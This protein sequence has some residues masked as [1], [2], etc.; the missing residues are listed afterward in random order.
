MHE[1][2]RAVGQTRGS[3][4]PFVLSALPSIC[5]D[6]LRQAVAVL[7]EQGGTA[8]EC[9]FLEAYANFLNRAVFLA[10]DLLNRSLLTEDHE[11]E[12]DRA[13][14]DLIGLK[15]PP[16]DAASWDRWLQEMV[17]ENASRGGG[18]SAALLTLLASDI[19]ATTCKHALALTNLPK[20]Y[21]SQRNLI[22]AHRKTMADALNSAENVADALRYVVEQ[23]FHRSGRVPKLIVFNDFDNNLSV[24]DHYLSLRPFQRT[25]QILRSTFD[26]L[27]PG[28]GRLRMTLVHAIQ[29]IPGFESV[30]ARY[31]AMGQASVILD[32]VLP[33][34]DTVRAVGGEFYILT[35]NFHSFARSA[36]RALGLEDHHIYSLRRNCYAGPEKPLTVST[37]V[38]ERPHDIFIVSDDGDHRLTESVLADRMH[39]ALPPEIQPHELT[40]FCAR[41]FSEHEG[42]EFPFQAALSAKGVPFGRNRTE[43][44]SEGGFYGYQG[45]SELVRAYA[46]AISDLS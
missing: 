37:T 16:I 29:Y 1:Q 35:A 12:R 7:S 5:D 32:D 11:Q 31:H 6:A 46:E 36:T 34:V 18:P 15:P 10:E 30:L 39:E 25:D 24:N 44:T 9:E 20:L 42:R 38:F 8:L 14:P 27:A 43:P 17:I 3:T 19:A 2:Q 13:I 21:Q 4:M 33:V 28:T 26:K 22:D 41:T 40:F 23:K 45:V